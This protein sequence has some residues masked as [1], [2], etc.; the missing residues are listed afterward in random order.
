MVVCC[1][2]PENTFERSWYFRPWVRNNLSIAAM[3]LGWGGGCGLI[4]QTLWRFFSPVELQSGAV[5]V[6]GEKTTMTR[7]RIKKHGTRGRRNKQAER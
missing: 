2:T 5:H 1:P 6:E 4:D 7:M 3:A